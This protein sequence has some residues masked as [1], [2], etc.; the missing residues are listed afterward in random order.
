MVKVYQVFSVQFFFMLICGISILDSGVGL[1]RNSS[2]G[3]SVD[4]I[5][6]NEMVFT[7]TCAESAK[8]D[9]TVVPDCQNKYWDVMQFWGYCMIVVAIFQLL[10]AL[11]VKP[12]IEDTTTRTRSSAYTRTNTNT[13]DDLDDLLGKYLVPTAEVKIKTVLSHPKYVEDV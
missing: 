3:V 8:P 2:L 4:S 7:L 12:S 5:W 9:G 1:A 13:E 10:K 6:F 11:M